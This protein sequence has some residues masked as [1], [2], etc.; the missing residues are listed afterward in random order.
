VKTLSAERGFTAFGGFREPQAC[1]PALAGTAWC[2]G[3]STKILVLRRRKRARLLADQQS[4]YDRSSPLRARR[5]TIGRDMR[6]AIATSMIGRHSLVGMFRVND[7]WRSREECV[8]RA[9]RPYLLPPALRVQPIRGS[10]TMRPQ[11]RQRA[12]CRWMRSG[13]QAGGR[14]LAR[15]RDMHRLSRRRRLRAAKTSSVRHNVGPP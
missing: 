10:R 5:T 1:G 2:P 15:N 4:R 11:T 3:H 13:P 8:K 14:T 7:A 12:W 6:I 9:F